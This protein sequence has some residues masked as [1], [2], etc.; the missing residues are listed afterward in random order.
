MGGRVRAI[1]WAVVG[2]RVL[3]GGSGGL[4]GRRGVADVALGGVLGGLLVGVTCEA[5]G[6]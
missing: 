6:K 5:R 2:V 4:A 3:V 1:G